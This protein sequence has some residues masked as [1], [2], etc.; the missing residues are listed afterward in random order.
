MFWLVLA[1]LS[2]CASAFPVTVQV[3][4]NERSCF[5]VQSDHVN[6][7]ASMSFVVL[8]GGSFDIDVTVRRPN[9]NVVEQLSKSSG[10][11]IAFT[12]TEVGEYELCFYN[13]MST[14]AD[15]KVEFDFNIDTSALRA[16][17]PKAIDLGANDDIERH[18]DNLDARFAELSRSLQY[19]K[20]RITR[21]QSTVSSTHERV[22]WF[23]LI[24]LGLVVA[25]AVLNVTVVQ[26]FFKGSRKTL[27]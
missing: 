8:S 3:P 1:I 17:L 26:L 16:E 23:S 19:Y 12:T 4:A 25:M 2:F 13:E 22:W 14:F 5:Y 27:V 9:G 11:E 21:N 10:D 15:K 20:A 7:K 24:E 6:S 18:I